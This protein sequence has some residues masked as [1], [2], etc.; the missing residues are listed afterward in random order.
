MMRRRC[1]VLLGTVAL[2][3]ALLPA[4]A[5]ADDT[6]SGPPSY[7][8]A[9]AHAQ[10]PDGVIG[11][12]F[13]VAA[14]DPRT[15]DEQP[16]AGPRP[17]AAPS[18]GEFAVY[19]TPD[20]TPAA[21]A[22]YVFSA[23]SLAESPTVTAVAPD[24]ART[25][26]QAS[27][28][29]GNWWRA[30]LPG[31]TPGVYRIDVTATP[32]DGSDALTASTTY[33]VLAPDR[34]VPAASAW[35]PIGPSSRGGLV[36]PD[37]TDPKTL[38]VASGI[39]AS[40]WVSHDGTRTWREEQTLPV[41]GGYPA[42]LVADPND[43]DRLYMA[44]DGNN[45]FA[46]IDPTYAGKIVTSADGGRTWSALSLPD[47]FVNGLAIDPT[48][49]TLAAVTADGIYV[50]HDRGRTWTHLDTPWSWHDYDG[51]V[52]VDDSLYVATFRGLY[53][54]RDVSSHPQAPVAVLAPG[55]ISNW[56]T[57]VAGDPGSLYANAWAGGV[58]V[59]H[60]A[61]A[62][63]THVLFG[64]GSL[65][66]MLADV[67]GTVYTNTYDTVW[68][69]RDHGSSWEQ[70]ADPSIDS[71][72]AGVAAVGDTVYISEWEAGIY[73][74]SDDGASY[75]QVGVPDT[76]A[77]ALGVSN[78]ASR[79]LAAT[80]WDV[81]S[82]AVR[83]PAAITQQ[84][85]GWDS[86]GEEGVLNA[87][88]TLM[89]SAGDVAYKI[90]R[91]FFSSAV[92][93]STDAGNTWQVV[94]SVRSPSGLLVDPTDPDRVFVASSSFFG[95]NVLE[96]TDG[97]ATWTTVNVPARFTTFA[98]DLSNPSRIWAGG[99]TGLYLSTD[100][101]ATFVQRD[102][103]PVTAL[104]APG[105]D[106]V[107]VGGDAL[108]YSDDGGASF[109]QATYPPVDI[110]VAAL[111]AAPETPSVVYAALGSSYEAGFLKGGRGV[112]RSTDG[113]RTWEPFDDGLDNLA[114][115]SLALSPD[116]GRLYVGTSHGGVF[117]QDVLSG[118]AG[119]SSGG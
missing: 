27:F 72:D 57:A 105:G 5:E 1:A 25:T 8:Q 10:N 13:G 64:S 78:S 113:G 46:V 29:Y 26:V 94:G 79:I 95:G 44:I 4:A 65:P 48:G 3:T 2:C 109:R 82:T 85:F 69:S 84:G 67:N 35:R 16:L 24:G 108:R 93:R 76:N 28:V 89:G 111:L 55:G 40:L 90:R 17:L 71:I 107:V 63:W 100:G 97:G 38:Y 52:L 102:S 18:T 58:Y 92:Q 61:G 74:T 59:S 98:V 62:T 7:A 110:S 56:V 118:R 119:E 43:G 54:V 66:G 12:R 81:Y 34:Q 39:S 50:S 117:E 19:T 36:V 20:P 88:V 99:L 22:A 42:A 75:K 21:S 47:V 14:S 30:P 104:S 37:P 60:D 53:A 31:G 51:L 114:A 101:G 45:G 73:A 9:A 115:V 77:Y 83:T 103:T 106:E 49:R 70:W 91:G 87:T 116:E 112:W 41:A 15:I 11:A 23:A 68:V 33:Q 6:N 80:N 86:P 96:T 32:V